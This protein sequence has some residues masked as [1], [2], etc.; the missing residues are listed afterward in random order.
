MHTFELSCSSF[1]RQINLFALLSEDHCAGIR[2]RY[3]L[4][5]TGEDSHHSH[6]VDGGFSKLKLRLI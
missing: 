4:L 1:W 5:F 2:D 3:N 6:C